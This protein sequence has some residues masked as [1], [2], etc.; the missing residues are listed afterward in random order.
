M[1]PSTSHRAFSS[2]ENTRCFRGQR[3]PRASGAN[4]CRRPRPAR[5]HMRAWDSPPSSRPP[6]A[7]AASRP[8]RGPTRGTQPPSV[9]PWR[10][11][12]SFWR[13]LQE[14][15]RVRGSR[16]SVPGTPPGLTEFHPV[17]PEQRPHRTLASRVSAP[18]QHQELCSS[19]R[20]AHLVRGMLQAPRLC[21]C[22]C[23]SGQS[24]SCR[25]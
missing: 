12:C 15:R 17:S 10:G 4:A 1:P 11:S 25:L 9:L 2:S 18:S 6:C 8:R 5:G 19:L 3:G 14:G 22:E 7:P 13:S 23:G 21:V 20:E 24:S 16:V